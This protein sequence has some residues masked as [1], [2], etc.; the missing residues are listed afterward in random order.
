VEG[1]P[2]SRVVKECQTGAL[3]AE[4]GPPPSSVMHLQSPL[5]FPAQYNMRPYL[6]FPVFTVYT[7]GRENIR[8]ITG[9]ARVFQEEYL[10][11]RGLGGEVKPKNMLQIL[12][13]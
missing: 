1:Q 10:V 11:F 7:Q 2:V 4:T 5:L 12:R 3:G 8:N 9:A 6:H 13:L